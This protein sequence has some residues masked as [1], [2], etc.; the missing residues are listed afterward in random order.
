MFKHDGSPLKLKSATGLKLE[1]RILCCSELNAKLMAKEGAKGN[2]IT[3]T[4][5]EALCIW[6]SLKEGRFDLFHTAVIIPFEKESEFRT[7][8]KSFLISNDALIKR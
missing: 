8:E 4:E 1:R 5:L 3:N 2:Q 6:F 7:E